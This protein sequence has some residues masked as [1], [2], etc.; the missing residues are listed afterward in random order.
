MTQR[1]IYQEEYPYFVTFCTREG[2]RLFEELK[3]AE[4]LSRDIFV[5]TRLKYF[6]VLAYQ[7]MPD[8]VHL[9]VW[10]DA[11]RV[12]YMRTLE[13]VRLGVG[14]NHNKQHPSALSLECDP[15]I[16]NISHLIQS[17]KGNFSRRVHRGNIW[18][19]RFHTRIVHT[20]RYFHAI[21][22]YIRCNPIKAELPPQFRRMPYQY[23][24]NKMIRELT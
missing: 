9:L 5:S 6:N 7:I 11:R 2:L 14:D 23:C 21:I 19:R 8:H 22:R 3:Y 1:R 12:S 4:W 15:V 16:P 18:Q 10:Q 13:K 24:D 17:I 20:D